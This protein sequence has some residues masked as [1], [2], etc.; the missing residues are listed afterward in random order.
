[1]LLACLSIAGCGSRPEDRAYAEVLIK[2]YPPRLLPG[3]LQF[4]LP[5]QEFEVYCQT[6]RRMVKSPFVLNAVLRHPEIARLSLLK[7]Q[8]H[9]F[10]FLEERLEVDFP[11]TEFMRISLNGAHSPD[12]VK[13]YQRGRDRISERRRQCGT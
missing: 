10:E 8:P 11:A 4:E 9:P 3:P 1:V 7:D 5:A 13:N 2:R 12:A 6:Q